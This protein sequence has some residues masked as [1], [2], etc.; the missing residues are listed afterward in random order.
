MSSGALAGR[1]A[2]ITGASRGIGAAV[3]KRF[4][5]E[6]AHVVLTARTIGGLE[7]VDDEIRAAGGS[8]TLAPLDLRDPDAIDV[9]CA[10]LYERFKR[11]DILVGHA[12]LL[13][14]LSPI[15]HIA[16]KNWDETFR[17]NVTANYRLL[18]GLDAVLRQSSSGRAI[19]TTGG[20][21][22]ENQPYWSLYASTKSALETMVK[23]YAEEVRRSNVK[24]N[25][26]DPV[27]VATVF[28]EK[29]F[30]GE[31]PETLPKPEDITDAYV[32]L[33]SPACT[34]SGTVV[35]LD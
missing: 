8:A 25:L 19:F 14:P 6:G 3:A 11:V 15:A 23:C 1:I 16:P 21:P 28:R 10:S 33:A 9:L 4:A 17:L 20:I 32:E 35:R 29:A 7:E 12:G 13:G 2:L 31:E 18:R 30:P 5:K 27:A 26:I 34:V 22:M 24:A